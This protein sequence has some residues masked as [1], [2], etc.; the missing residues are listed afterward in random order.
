MKKSLIKDAFRQIYKNP[1]RFLAIFAIVAIGTAFFAGIKA[2]APNMKYTADQYYDQYNLMDFRLLS[3]LGFVQEDIDAVKK[4][5]GVE[6]VQPS[7]FVDVTNTVGTAEFVF[8]VHSLPTNTSSDFI[9][10]P[11]IVEGRLPLKEGECIIESN[12]NLDL[13]YKIGDTIKVASGKDEPVTDTLKHD[14]Y[15]I[16]GLAESPYYL[17]YDKD[18]SDIGSGKV[19]FFMMVPQS[20]FLYPVYTEIV[21][22]VQGAKE[23]NSYEGAYKKLI[24]AV[25]NKLENLGDKRA[26]LRLE[27]IKAKAYEQLNQ[28]KAELAAQEASFNQ[29]I[30]DGEN[31]L[32]AA[33]DEL[34]SGQATLEEQKISS[35]IEIAKAEQQLADAKVAYQQA[36]DQYNTANSL[37][38]DSQ[39]QIDSSLGNL[40]NL[41]SYL[42]SQ[43]A[44]LE[45]QLQN[46]NLTPD[47]R[48]NLESQLSQVNNLLDQ[49]NQTVDN[50]NGIDTNINSQLESAAAQLAVAEQQIA[51]GEAQLA[52]AK[53]DRDA[54]IAA[55]EARLAAGRAEY[56]A[57]AADLAAKKA[58]GEK[59]IQEAKIKLVRAENEI[60]RLAE[61]TWYVLDRNKLYSYADYAATADRMDAISALFPVF[62]FAVAALVS[63]TSMTRM[64]DEQRTS[65]GIYK[66]LGY[67]TYEIA[68][69]FVNYASIATILGGILGVNVGIA[70]FPKIIFDS[71]AI[72]YT[73]P[74]MLQANHLLM[75]VLTV[76]VAFLLITLTAYW[77]IRK[78]LKAV[79]AT[80]MRPKAAVAGKTIF[81]EKIHWFWNRLNFTQKVTMR[82]IFRYKKRFIMTVIGIAGCSALIVAGFGINDSIGTVVRNQYQEIFQFDMSAKFSPE[83]TEDQR[84]EVYAYMTNNTA[85]KQWMKISQMNSSVKSGDE[86]ISATMIAPSNIKYF[87]N[88]VL[89]RDRTF[90]NKIT[91][92]NSGIVIDEKLATD[93]GVSVGDSIQV[94]NG[95]GSFKKLE[96]A[97]ITE[98]YI[99]HY[100]YI[101][102]A[103][104]EEVYGV[105]PDNNAMMMTLADKSKEEQIGKELIGVPQVSSVLY[106]T[107]AAETF[108][109]SVKS[110]NSIIYAIITCAGILAFVVLYNLT[111]INISERQREIATIKV[112][113]FYNKEL[114]GYVYR[115]NNLLTIFG[116]LI[117][118]PVGLALHRAIMISI[119]QEAVMFGYYISGWSLLIAFV[120]TVVFGLLANL[121]MYRKVTSI[122]MVESLKSIE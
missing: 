56:D 120:S 7:Y 112:L 34:A 113:G 82:N 12:K 77:G 21:L 10:M 64:I 31:R 4:V 51:D 110:L 86:E 45:T 9:N 20:E 41:Q 15:T 107:D 23:L 36:L 38:Q 47:E 3:T 72:M 48:A 19:N 29:Q 90:Q 27:E 84:L 30:A 17:T 80:L 121:F 89:L 103:Y 8:R 75:M 14:S 92:G 69:K 101:T 100:I 98:N 66:A 88:Y 46:P 25:G 24:E 6:K 44:S 52:A 32:A 37:L 49:T 93:L 79:P 78:E 16:V 13:G 40:N 70:I 102:P 55:A 67:G 57:A 108:K 2:A 122:K 83:S 94:D 119:E 116:A 1:G 71:W 28:A 111:N 91:L 105:K 33:R 43:K 61:P 63:L 117:G 5:D 115:E 85:V 54:Q 26:A 68:Y 87:E 118:L 96:V 53:A 73:L 11:K 65:I 81:L 74:P 109:D 50:V 42:Q 22:T 104:Y 35:A 59:Q 58:E 99:F 114:A 106:Y 97:A 76:V 39:G 95:E 18:A 60:E 62:F